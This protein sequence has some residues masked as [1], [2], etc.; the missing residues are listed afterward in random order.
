[1]TQ[2]P[3]TTLTRGQRR[4]L[5]GVSAALGLVILAPISLSMQDLVAWAESPQHLGLHGPWP[6][7]VPIALDLAA[8][9]CIGMTIVAAQR[10]ERPGWFGKLVWVFA[11]GS[12]YAQ[13]VFGAAEHDAGRAQDKWWAMPAFALLGPLLLDRVLH[14]TRRWA[15]QEAGEQLTGAAGFGARWLPGVAVVETVQ[16]WAA[17]RR[18]GIP[19]AADAIQF[20]RDR[21]ALRR[22]HPV[23]ALHYAFGALG[24]VTPHAARV[25]L[26]ARGVHVTQADVDEATA[27]RLVAP[28]PVSGPPAIESGAAVGYGEVA[29]PSHRE[30]LDAYEFGTDRIKYAAAALVMA[31]QQPTGPAILRWLGE[32]GYPHADRKEA[33]RAAKKIREG[34]A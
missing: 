3:P 22:L 19:R 12:A 33:F 14:R 1:M 15:R 30:Q 18:E 29:Y 26:S 11:L 4:L 24:V 10:R 32:W 31:G 23:E 8:A 7:I 27:G 16:A 2:K 21:K 9:L 25:W 13:Y 17:S 20:V 6:Y 5:A 28:T 34:A